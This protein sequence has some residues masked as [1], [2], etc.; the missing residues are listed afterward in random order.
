MSLKELHK[1]VCT[2]KQYPSDYDKTVIEAV[3]TI[4]IPKKDYIFFGTYH[5]K[6]LIYAGDIDILTLNLNINKIGEYMQDIIRRVIKKGYIIGDIKAGIKY[7]YVGLIHHVGQIKNSVIVGYNPVK[8][9]Q[10][11][12]HYGLDLHIP[13]IYGLTFP[14]WIELYDNIHKLITLRWRPQDILNGYLI[15]DNEKYELNDVIRHYYQYF[16]NKIDIYFVHDG[17][18]I[19]MTNIYEPR[20]WDNRNE[21]PKIRFGMLK[22]LMPNNLNYAKALKRAYSVSR[23]EGNATILNKIVP[24]LTSDINFM[25]SFVTDINIIF[26]IL[27]AG[28]KL[29]D[30]KTK[31]ITHLHQLTIKMEKLN[32]NKYINMINLA[33]THIDNEKTFI[34]ILT[35]VVKDLIIIINKLTL[36]YIK[37]YEINLKSLYP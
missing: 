12:D 32:M 23:I 31:I 16:L 28:N 22:L 5:F 18:I 27:D 30:I 20:E 36:K 26:D 13:H 37:D 25:A 10:I 24:F 33:L 11:V 14:K 15:S 21:I 3:K 7:K 4:T 35:F 34:K 8:L 2:K 9:K 29:K 17:R 1:F 6:S 19:E